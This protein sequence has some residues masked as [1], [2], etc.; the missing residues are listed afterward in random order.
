MKNAISQA[1]LNTVISKFQFEG[2]F[3]SSQRYGNGHINDT[4]LLEFQNGLNVKKYILQRINKYVF[5]NPEQVMQNI[6]GVTSFLRNQ[7]VA[8][9]GDPD[10]ETL[11]VIKCTDQSGYYIDSNGDY[12]RAYLF[13]DDTLS[14]DLPETKDDF[15]QSAVGFG[16]FQ[17]QLSTYPAETLYETIPNFHNTPVRFQNFI[18]AVNAD[19]RGRAQNALKEITFVKEREAFTHVLEDLHASGKLPK[20]VTHNDTK[21]NNVLLDRTT[22]KS[23]CIVDLD[24]V[25]PGYSVTDFGDSIRFGAST[26]AEDEKDLSKVHFDISLF[27]IYAKGFLDACGESLTPEEIIHLPEGAKMMTLECGMRFLAD[28][29]EGDVYF[30]TAY[31]DHNL[32]RCRTQLKLVEEMEQQWEQM[33]QIVSKY[34]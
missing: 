8:Q 7:I 2:T 33:K 19:P 24:T 13:V 28:Y 26:A 11:N 30:K 15:Y 10:R 6:I 9:G 32:V 5:K 20:R 23:L 4:Y 21:I 16:E 1:D 31:D 29:I 17:R 34:I 27:E 14:L 3:L 18:A 12:W 22:R 25:M